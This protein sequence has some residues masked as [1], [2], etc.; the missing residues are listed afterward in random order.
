MPRFAVAGKDYG[1]PFDMV[2]DNS[3]PGNQPLFE[4]TAEP[5]TLDTAG[6]AKWRIRK[7]FYD[8]NNILMGWRWANGRDAFENDW[9][10]R[11]S[12]TYT[13]L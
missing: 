5:G 9:T 11:A 4:G 13:S 12:Q 10:L 1:I 2:T 3:G 8:S 7:F 6:T